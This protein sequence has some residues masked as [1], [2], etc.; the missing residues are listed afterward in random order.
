MQ[1]DKIA[2]RSSQLIYTLGSFAVAVSPSFITTSSESTTGAGG[3]LKNAPIPPDVS[4]FFGFL[5]FFGSRIGYES[6]GSLRTS[7]VHS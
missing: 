3:L 5:V 4:A 7:G 1:D 6:S 2:V